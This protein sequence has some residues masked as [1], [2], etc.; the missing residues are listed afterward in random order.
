MTTLAIERPKAD[1]HSPYFAR[2]IDRVPDGNLIALLESQFADTRALL[3]RVP[4]EREDFAYAEGKWSVKEVVGHLAD[5]ERVFAYR[6]LRFA[7]GDATE[8]AGYDE[9]AWVANAGFGRQRLADLVDEFSAVRASTIRFV[10]SLNA[11]ELARRG[12]A[13]GNGIT[14]RALV[15]II[16]GHER[17][18]VGL[19][20]ER[21]QL[22]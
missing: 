3:E 7:R 9:N 11:E 8:L 21:Y 4:R 13:N 22:S 18:H 19:F 5:S 17:H 14:V 10:K 16:A 20:R 12:V 1:E 6:A 15:Y 2:Y